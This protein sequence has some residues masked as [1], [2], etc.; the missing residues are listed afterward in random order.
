MSTHR[1]G[2]P[3]AVRRWWALV[4]LLTGT[5]GLL[6]YAYSSSVTPAYEADATLIVQSPTGPRGD[7]RLAGVALPTIAELVK[8]RPVLEGAIE[9]LGLPLTPEEL[10]PDVRGES[11]SE[12]SLLT[13]RARYPD[14]SVAV[15]LANA[16][17]VELRSLVH[18]D[19]PRGID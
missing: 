9:R 14:A 11:I 17:A 15:A 3:S 10:A 19:D 13:I 12:T 6:G 5:G 8:S 18:S 16:L 7:F 4:V 2:V 1:I